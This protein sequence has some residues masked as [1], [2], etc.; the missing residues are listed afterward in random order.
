M[1][2]SFDEAVKAIKEG[3]IIIYPTD[4]AFGIG[5]RIDN[6]T[7]VKRLFEA[8]KRPKEKAVPVLFDSI[9]QVKEYVLP[10]DRKVKDLMEKYWPGALTIVLKCKV[11][12][13]S[14][15][16]RGGGDTLGVRVPSYKPL[17][18]LI[19]T[20]GVPIVGTS[21]NF[22]GNPTPFT[23]DEIDKELIKKVEGVLELDT[24]KINT[25][26]QT[27]TIIDCTQEPWKILRQGA[28]EISL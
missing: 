8:R 24:S 9:D 14:S 28:I 4:T 2:L 27:S 15:L 23:I 26:S 18:D 25:L 7:A 19:K 11:S 16:V 21:A 17:R 3:G 12:K 6:K 5:C 1:N 10:F 20:V 22:A 13:V